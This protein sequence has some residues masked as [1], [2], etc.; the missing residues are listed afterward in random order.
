MPR[1]VF[2]SAVTVVLLLVVLSSFCA[3]AAQERKA[4][5]PPAAVRATDEDLRKAVGAPIDPTTYVIGP[6]DVLSIRVWR[7]PELSGPVAVRPDGKISLPLVGDLQAGGVT[8]EKLAA[9]IK[10]VL[11]KYLTNPEV[12][13]SVVTVNSKKYFVSGE[14]LRPGSYPLVVP[15]TVLEALSIAGGFRDFANTKR[16]LILRGPKQFKFNW[17]D[18]SRGQNM[19]Q[20]ILLESGDHIIVP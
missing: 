6:E 16:V 2:L 15:T 12:M 3:L 10:E 14:V 13:A 4:D 20:N 18:V 9:Q 17:R 11:T 7:E 8:P 19:A 5:A 1:S